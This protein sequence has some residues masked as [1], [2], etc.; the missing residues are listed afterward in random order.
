MQRFFVSESSFG[1]EW[2]Q[3]SPEQAHQVCHVLRL[4]AGDSVVLL[5]NAGFEYDAALLT[6]AGHEATCRVTARRPASGEPTVQLTLFQSLLAREKF[7]WVLQKGTEVGVTRFVPV[8]TQRSIVR[9][10]KI[11][12]KKLQRWHRILTEAA[13]QSHRGR[14][15][16]LDQE[17]D[18][19]EAV[20]GLADFDRALVA[21]PSDGAVSLKEALRSQAAAP[22]SVALLIGP[23]GGFVEAEVALACESGALKI[24]LGPRVLRTETAAVV[25]S[26]LILYEFD[27]MRP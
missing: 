16:H 5:D 11:D 20:S 22:S 19:A 9:A 10:R 1:G 2:V 21:A 13:E 17:M 26:A 4:R 7:E 25:A 6:V 8:R 14:I 15:P 3:L 23:E 18:F 24:T 27:Q 12:E